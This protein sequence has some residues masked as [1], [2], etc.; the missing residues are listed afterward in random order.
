MHWYSQMGLWLFVTTGVN[1]FSTFGWGCTVTYALGVYSSCLECV[2][3]RMID[4]NVDDESIYHLFLPSSFLPS[5]LLY[6]SIQPCHSILS[7]PNPSP[8]PLPSSPTKAVSNH[9]INKCTPNNSISYYHQQL[10]Y[11]WQLTIM[12]RCSAC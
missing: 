4:E 11:R 2:E 6:P 1:I 10:T 12:G 8:P 3:A 7:Q 9:S 5:S